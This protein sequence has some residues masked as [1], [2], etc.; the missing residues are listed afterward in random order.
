MLAGGELDRRRLR[1][2]IEE[3][4]IERFRDVDGDKPRWQLAGRNIFVIDFR[5]R[6]SLAV[7]GNRGK[8]MIGAD[9]H[10]GRRVEPECF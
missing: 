7:F 3:A 8:A 2:R 10:I 9:D 5:C 1:V 4:H 6:A